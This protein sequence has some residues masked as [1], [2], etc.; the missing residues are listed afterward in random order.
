MQRGYASEGVFGRGGG[1]AF[2][3]ER[4]SRSYSF[5]DVAESI[6][7]AEGNGGRYWAFCVCVCTYV[8]MAVLY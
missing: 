2:G 6:C 8:C 1:K 5:L 4:W 7:A 3:D